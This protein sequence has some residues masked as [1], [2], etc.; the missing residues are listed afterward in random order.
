MGLA[1]LWRERVRA[2]I[3]SISHE[4]TARH[5]LHFGRA[6]L[7]IEAG[8]NGASFALTLPNANQNEQK[9]AN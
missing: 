5:F 8:E 3:P 9:R 2:R 6:A 7:R 4:I 1:K